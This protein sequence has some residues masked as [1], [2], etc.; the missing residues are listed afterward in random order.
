MQTKKIKNFTPEVQVMGYGA[1]GLGV[2]KE[3]TVR[4]A[5]RWQ[6][7]GHMSSDD[8]KWHDKLQWVLE[9]NSLDFQPTHGSI[10]HTA[11]AMEHNARRFFMTVHVSGQ[12]AKTSDKVKK[13]FKFGT[14][15]QGIVTS[16]HWAHDY[17]HVLPL[18]NWANKLN[19]AMELENM[20]AI[21]VEMPSALP[22]R[23]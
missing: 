23:S 22:Y 5:G 3:K 18:D 4:T 20:A 10:F 6:F 1:G 16:I 2:K 7:S 19:Y 14:K 15:D 12:L 11:F 8:G 21:P 13:W 9:E 17:P